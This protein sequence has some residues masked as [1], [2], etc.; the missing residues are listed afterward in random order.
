MALTEITSK[1]I[2]D[3]E[4]V[5]ADVNASAAIAASKISGLAASATTDTRDASNINSG[6]L[7]AARIGDDSI[8]EAK[9]DIHAAPSGTDKFLGYTS[10]G[11][12]WTTVPA[13]GATIN[14]ATEN[15][16][17]TVAS[18]TSQLDAEAKFTYDGNTAVLQTTSDGNAINVVRNS[19]DTNP[20]NITLTKSRNA[21]YGSNTIINNADEIGEIVWKADDGTDYASEVAAI[22]VDISGIPGGNDT[23]GRMEFFTTAD[24][25]ATAS[26]RLTISS[27][28]NLYVEDGNVQLGQSGNG[29]EFNNFGSGATIS[30][31][32][33]DDYEVGTWT[34][35]PSF[36]GGTT[37]ITGSFSGTYVK[38]GKIV[39]VYYTVIFTNKG[40]STGSAML[41]G[42]PFS[43]GGGAES[44]NNSWGYF[45]RMTFDEANDMQAMMNL[46]GTTSYMRVSKYGSGPN[47]AAVTEGYFN[48][49][50]RY[51]GCMVYRI[52]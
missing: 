31:N 27:E 3:G 9:L 2:K 14:N 50:S 30:S 24:G 16:I 28:G 17:V 26:K 1:S 6:T 29:I 49:S 7:P 12:E 39:T 40:S 25:A 5:N 38:V 51:D 23:P 36:S 34:P 22:K 35:A 4:I 47:A 8:V 20:V 42:F 44:V 21:T 15:E 41:G 43:N 52:S 18:T 10:N 48:N 32:N 11:M 37:G 19:A 45:H 13:G 33:L 46:D